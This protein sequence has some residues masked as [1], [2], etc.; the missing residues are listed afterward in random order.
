[1]KIPNYKKK[2][3]SV[4]G[5][6]YECPNHERTENC[7]FKKYDSLD[8]NERVEQ[9]ELLTQNELEKTITHHKNCSRNRV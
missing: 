6:A 3:I 2:N 5:L 1:M 4:F 8:F 7:P 9:I